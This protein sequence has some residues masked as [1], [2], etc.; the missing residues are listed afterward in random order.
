LIFFYFFEEEKAKRKEKKRRE[1]KE[2][3]KREE[4]FVRMK[5]NSVRQPRHLL[6][7]AKTTADFC[8]VPY[9]VVIAS[10]L[11]VFSSSSHFHNR[12]CSAF[13]SSEKIDDEISSLLVGGVGGGGE[14]E[15][16][17]HISIVDDELDNNNNSNNT[18]C[19]Y[20]IDGDGSIELES[21][22]SSSVDRLLISTNATFSNCVF[23][24][25]GGGDFNTSVSIVYVTPPNNAS[26]TATTKPHLTVTFFNCTFANFTRKRGSPALSLVHKIY[27]KND[28]NYD[29]D[30][31]NNDDNNYD[32]YEE[33]K[34]TSFGSFDVSLV[35]CQFDSN[36]ISISMKKFLAERTVV[37]V[38][39]VESTFRNNQQSAVFIN[40]VNDVMSHSLSSHLLQFINS[41][42]IDNYQPGYLVGGSVINGN[43]FN[44]SI[45]ISGCLFENNKAGAGG[46]AISISEAAA[47]IH[48]ASSVFRNNHVIVTGGGGAMSIDSTRNLLIVDCIFDSNTADCQD[49]IKS[50]T[51]YGQQYCSGG[52]LEVSQSTNVSI[53][54]SVFSNNTAA[55]CGGAVML[56]KPS[57]AYEDFDPTTA[58]KTTIISGCHFESN[59]A[60]NGGAI[61][62]VDDLDDNEGNEDSDSKKDYL[63]QISTTAFQ[64]NF[65]K[66][67]GGSVYYAS[68]L[69][70]TISNCTFTRSISASAGAGLFVTPQGTVRLFDVLFLA[71]FVTISYCQTDCSGAAVFNAGVFECTRCTFWD[72][73]GLTLGNVIATSGNTTCDQCVFIDNVNPM[74]SSRPAIGA[75]A[76]RVTISNSVFFNNTGTIAAFDHPGSFGSSTLTVIFTNCTIDKVR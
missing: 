45:F 49:V 15:Q 27:Q 23:S 9:S 75:W 24:P 68:T 7:C 41:S 36:Y 39:V 48:I 8:Y 58:I 19:Q 46:G 1:A 53:V 56:V 72:N 32:S 28:T 10:L 13:S 30:N 64:E 55:N 35:G 31:D 5:R 59:Q 16:Q 63:I 66:E 61:Y 44:V 74:P 69:A 33:E 73:F 37:N 4:S 62:I 52:A 14:E 18:G 26:S 20:T 65:A 42:F 43:S 71:G 57:E 40:Y 3:A 21:E 12:C 51:K 60:N 22:D 29:Y 11:L 25:L 50:Q 38:S 54:D 17:Q 2:K 76:G 67:Y 70:V 47:L 34:E 6:R